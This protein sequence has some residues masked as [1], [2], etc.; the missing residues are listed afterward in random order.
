MADNITEESNPTSSPPPPPAAKNIS[1]PVKTE[2]K[3]NT[4]SATLTTNTKPKST[5][6]TTNNNNNNNNTPKANSTTKP[7]ATPS[8]TSTSKSKESSTPPQTKTSEEPKVLV[9][10]A[11]HDTQEVL[12][13]LL[14]VNE[15][16]HSVTSMWGW[17]S[18]SVAKVSETAVNL[19]SV[20]ETATK[21]ITKALNEEE[22]S[23]S[24]SSPSAIHSTQPK[25]QV[26]LPWETIL[27]IEKRNEAKERILKLSMEDQTFTIPPPTNYIYDVVTKEPIAHRMLEV[28]AL[29]SAKRFKLVPKTLD[30]VEFWKNYFYRVDLILNAMAGSAAVIT[31]NQD[32]STTAASA[33]ST[34]VS[35]ISSNELEQSTNWEEEMRKEVMATTKE[36]E[37]FD[38]LDDDLEFDDDDLD[39]S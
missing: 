4:K 1:T 25:S 35:N 39:K 19:K 31:S 11:H 26:I 5:P 32:V 29:L 20:A 2:T 7:K 37:N 22:Q 17:M 23:A 15:L 21:Q 14:D 16:Q 28:D 30:E 3:S 13:R 9:V 38:M 34:S 10:E 27:I 18:S 36:D 6:N 12:D 24:T 33:I 8:S